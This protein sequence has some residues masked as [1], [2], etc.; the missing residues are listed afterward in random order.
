MYQLAYFRVEFITCRSVRFHHLLIVYE[1]KRTITSC[2]AGI[3]SL[4][5]VAGPAESRHAIGLV[6]SPTITILHSPF[7]I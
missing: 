4:K 5:Q 6:P 1:T 2:H 3:E 7:A